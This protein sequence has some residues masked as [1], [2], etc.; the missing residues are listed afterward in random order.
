MSIFQLSAYTVTTALGRGLESHW[1][2]L[3][4][5]KSGLRRCDLEGVDLETWIG[6]VE[7]LEGV[8]LPAAL[9][10]FDCRNNRLAHMALGEDDFQ[11][12]VAEARTHYGADRVGVFIGT[13]TSGIEESER[14]YLQRDQATGTLP[15]EFRYHTTQATYSVAAY[16]RRLLRLNGPAH[17]TSTAC[18]SSAK[19]FATARRFISAGL[20]DAAVIGGVDSLCKMTLY[21]FNSLELISAERCRPADEQRNGINIG[22]GAGFVL[23]ERAQSENAI[24]LLGYGESSDAFHMSTPHPEGIGAALAIDGALKDA[25]LQ[26]GEIDYINLHG[27]ATQANDLCEDRAVSRIFGNTVPCSSTKG[28]TGHTLGAAGIVEAIFSAIAVERGIVFR[29][30]NT[31]SVDNRISSR[32]SL[33]TTPT[34]I[35]RVLSNSFGFGGS[36][37]C[38]IVGRP[39]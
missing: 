18:S 4:A 10:D 17:V 34:K 14:T 29:S 13:S 20:C 33:A 16:V 26:P 3:N 31:Q 35:N 28:F 15:A 11:L 38:L 22:E 6:R 25:Q 12:R 39:R 21:G 23:L 27:T 32:I 1:C 7:D 5:E 24:S 9:S 2:A 19:V 37:A 36:N 30:L 8:T